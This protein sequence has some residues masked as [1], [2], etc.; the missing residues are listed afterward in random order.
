VRRVV[1]PWVR[2]GDSGEDPSRVSVNVRTH[3][4]SCLLKLRDVGGGWT[5]FGI[6]GLRVDT[7]AA[8]EEGAAGRSI[9]LPM[10]EAAEVAGAMIASSASR[11]LVSVPANKGLADSSDGSSNRSE[12]VRNALM[13]GQHA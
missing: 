11:K 10:A 5:F 12:G 3:L 6:H 13:W 1:V 9:V 7:D 8:R 2:C 4:I